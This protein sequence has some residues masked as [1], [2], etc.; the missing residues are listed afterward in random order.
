MGHYAMMCCRKKKKNVVAKVDEFSTKFE[1]EFYFVVNI[2]TNV[3]SFIL[4]YISNDSIVKEDCIG[5]I[6]F[7]NESQPPLI[8][9]KV[10]YVLGLRNNLMSI[11]TIEGKGYEVAFHD[12]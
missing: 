7:K 11:S 4:W 3:S 10:L 6:S 5:I 1:K 2:F 8:E 12:G 9:I